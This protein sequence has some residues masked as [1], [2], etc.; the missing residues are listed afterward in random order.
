MNRIDI[1]GSFSGVHVNK[2]PGTLEVLDPEDNDSLKRAGSRKPYIC[3]GQE[4]ARDDYQQPINSHNGTLEVLG[5]TEN[6]F[7]HAAES[8]SRPGS[9]ACRQ[10]SAG[11]KCSASA[12]QISLCT[13]KRIAPS[14]NIADYNVADL[15]NSKKI[16][17][18]EARELLTGRPDSSAGKNGSVRRKCCASTKQISLC[19]VKRITPSNNIPDY[20]VADLK[21]LK[22]I[23]ADPMQ[24]EPNTAEKD[25]TEVHSASIQ[26]CI[27][28]DQPQ[29]SSSDDDESDNETTAAPLQLLTEFI[30]AAMDED[31]K[32]A[33]KL[34]QM[35]LIYEPENPEAKEFSPLIQK[36]LQNEEDHA[37]NDGDSEDTDE[38]DD[39]SDTDDSDSNSTETSEA[40]SEDEADN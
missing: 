22:K 33:W 30:K 11:R 7:V 37:S 21:N 17:H 32:L 4:F 5:P 14:S 26:S 36:M 3:D 29:E 9:S 24:K 12:K 31:Y 6:V 25:S 1:R 20:N 23:D 16:D 15:K 10:G 35:I 2:V 34:C 40:S 39:G 27:L 38:D 28:T 18:S 8:S 13:V 19:T